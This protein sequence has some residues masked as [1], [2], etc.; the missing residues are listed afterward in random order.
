MSSKMIENQDE[1]ATRMMSGQSRGNLCP[2][3]GLD[4]GR[5]KQ[6]AQEQVAGEKKQKIM[7]AH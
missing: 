5:G 6:P 1:Q 2:Y 4:V 7:P 3:S